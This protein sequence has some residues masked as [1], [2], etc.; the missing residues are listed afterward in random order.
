ML[1]LHALSEARS[2]EAV[3]RDAA[4]WNRLCDLWFA[5]TV[6]ELRQEEKG[7]WS[8][9]QLE[10]VEEFVFRPLIGETPEAAIDAAMQ[11][12]EKNRG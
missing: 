2:S 11:A 7:F 9:C 10:P 4:R 3:E 8:I 12:E 5:S 1:L 6:L